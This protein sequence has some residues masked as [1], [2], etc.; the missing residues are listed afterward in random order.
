IERPPE[1]RRDKRAVLF[2]DAGAQGC[3]I[4]P[5]VDDR[6]VRESD[7]LTVDAQ[8]YTCV[9]E[10]VESRRLRRQLRNVHVQHSRRFPHAPLRRRKR[11][12]EDAPD[13][14]STGLAV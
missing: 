5:A 13:A 2:E 12:A 1:D 4:E 6:H 14:M 8:E 10:S 7:R 11:S 3:W 9:A